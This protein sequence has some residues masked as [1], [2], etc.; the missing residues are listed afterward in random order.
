MENGTRIPYADGCKGEKVCKRKKIIMKC[1]WC[2]Y[3]SDDQDDFELEEKSRGFWCPECDKFTYFPGRESPQI[4]AVLLEQGSTGEQLPAVSETRCDRRISPLRYPGGKSRMVSFISRQIRQ[5]K[6]T[7]IEPFC[8]GSSVGLALLEAG[9]I[10]HLILNDLD[11]GVYS[12][13]HV[14]NLWRKPI[15]LP[16]G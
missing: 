4:I 16:M 9:K 11:F 3:E 10:E 6:T 8:G 13:F 5:G 2:G 1:T 15:G 12:L 7:F 14:I